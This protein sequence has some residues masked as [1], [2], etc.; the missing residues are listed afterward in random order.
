MDDG[1]VDKKQ[2]KYDNVKD[3][4]ELD[5]VS[6]LGQS[7]LANIVLSFCCTGPRAAHTFYAVGVMGKSVPEAVHYWV[8]C[9]LMIFFP[10]CTLFICNSFTDLN[11]RLGGEKK[12]W[13]TGL[14]CA[15]CCSCCVVNQDAQS[16]DILMEHDTNFCGVSK[17]AN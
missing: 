4:Q 8:S 17:A 12:W 6:S 2:L 3:L 16:L 11:E 13:L 1:S 5:E 10:C 15:C 9:L 14:L 7:S